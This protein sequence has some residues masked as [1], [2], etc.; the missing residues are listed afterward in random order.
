[1]FDRFFNLP[2]YSSRQSHFSLND[3]VVVEKDGSYKLTL[4][5]PGFSRENVKLSIKENA[6][7]I[8]L[9]QEQKQRKVTYRLGKDVDQ[10]KIKATCKDG[11]LTVHCPTR[12]LEEKI[13][14]V[15]VD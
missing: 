15:D 7:N 10:N 5:V 8:E 1:M 3:E 6:L 13:I 11:I 12:Q 2:V 9:K 14:S 4:E